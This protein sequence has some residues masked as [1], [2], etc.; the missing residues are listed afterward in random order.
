[1]SMSAQLQPMVSDWERALAV[2]AHPDDVEFGA[3]GAVAAWTAAGKSVAYVL[4]TRGEAGIDSL[5][6]AKAAEVREAEQRAGAEIVGVREVE[7]LDHT[8]GVIE[9]G[10]PLRR[11]IT[12]AIRR[13]RPELIVIFNHHD[14]F[15]GGKRNSPD[16]RHTGQATLDAIGDA[17]NRWIFPELTAEPWNG[18]RYVAVAQ[19]PNPTHAIDISVTLDLAVASLEAHRSYLDGIGL[20][21]VRGPLTAITTGFGQRY[22]GNPS[23]VFELLTR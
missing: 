15:P 12:D 13:H 5:N 8:D 19:S 23:L 9:Y 18:V 10:V 21:D 11:D 22:N 7:F 14:T 20:T 16:H 3:A 17:G 6:P 1:M 2:V 4:L